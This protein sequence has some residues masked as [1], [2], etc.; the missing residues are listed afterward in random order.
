[1]V[2]WKIYILPF[3]VFPV[4]SEE[5]VLLSMK[6]LIAC[7]DTNPKIIIQSYLFFKNIEI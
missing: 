1:M 2:N 6:K 3:E 7:T 4:E 5:V